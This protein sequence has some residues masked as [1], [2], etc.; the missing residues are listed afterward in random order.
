MPAP[1]G[2]AAKPHRLFGVMFGAEIHTG[3]EGSGEGSDSSPP[4]GVD[5]G[6]LTAKLWEQGIAQTAPNH[7]WRLAPHWPN[8]LDEPARL[9]A[10]L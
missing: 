7:C 1:D 10:A 3:G 8:S 5:L 9:V 2:E 6:A 4:E